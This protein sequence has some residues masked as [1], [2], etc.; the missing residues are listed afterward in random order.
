MINVNEIDL[1]PMGIWRL[2]IFTGIFSILVLFFKR[3]NSRVTL[4]LTVYFLF[5]AY[6]VFSIEFPFCRFG[7]YQAAFASSA[8]RTCIELIFVPFAFILSDNKNFVKYFTYFIAANT[9]SIWILKCG[10]MLQ[11]SFD[12]SLAAIFLP[13]APIWLIFFVL[14]TMLSHHG[15]TALLIVA[16]EVFAFCLK[17][18]KV[19][20]YTTYVMPFI[21]VLGLIRFKDLSAGAHSRIDAWTEF[22]M[23]WWHQGWIV[24]AIGFGPGSFPCIS[25]LNYPGKGELF[26]QMHSD[27]L[28]FI[29]EYGILGFSLILSVLIKSIKECW[30]DTP[31]LAA[32]FG[33]AAFATTYHPMRFM[34]T[35]I[36]VTYIFWRALNKKAQE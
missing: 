27:W 4:E 10:I 25:I 33:C 9:A 26:I 17:D 32:L 16:A 23:V 5:L 15:S 2:G 12:C 6:C 8:G 30:N 18:R 29:F 35:M 22:M 34:P 1:D 36:L 13:F 7:I 14:V 28:Q 11:P 21:V 3:F 24:R 31:M 20:I 19:R